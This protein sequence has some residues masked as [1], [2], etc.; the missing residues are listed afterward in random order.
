MRVPLARARDGVPQQGLA[1]ESARKRELA[2]QEWLWNAF[3]VSSLPAHSGS[4]GD[5]SP[6]GLLG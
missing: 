1:T 3:E 2:F 5:F 4:W 6:A